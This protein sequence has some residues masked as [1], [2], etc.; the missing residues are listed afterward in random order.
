MLDNWG[1]NMTNEVVKKNYMDLYIRTKHYLIEI[2]I[3]NIWHKKTL[4][5]GLG[6]V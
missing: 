2:N 3:Q 6:R 5:M 1:Y 4:L